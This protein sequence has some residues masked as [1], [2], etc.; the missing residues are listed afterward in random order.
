MFI[1]PRR[2]TS[3]HPQGLSLIF[4]LILVSIIM[5]IAATMTASFLRASQLN[6]DLFR[7]T[8]AYYVARA[9]M[10][11]ALEDASNNGIGYENTATAAASWDTTGNGTD[12]VTGD[13]AIYA[14]GKTL[15]WIDAPTTDSCNGVDF[16]YIPIPG[17]GNAGDSCDFED[18]SQTWY[19][20]SDEACN[21]NKIVY[22]QTVTIPL[23]YTDSTGTQMN[24][25]TSGDLF[26]LKIR[27]PESSS[28]TR[29]SLNSTLDDEVIVNWEIVA[30]CDDG[31]SVDSC[32]ITGYETLG[33]GSGP[34][35]SSG[36]DSR[37]L[38]SVINGASS[39]AVLEEDTEGIDNLQITG[40][41]ITEFLTN[42]DPGHSYSAIENHYLKISVI[43]P[44]IDSSGTSI[45][46]L[47][48]QL[49]T[50]VPFSTTQIIYTADGHADGQLGTYNRHLQAIQSIE[51]N[52][53]INFVIQN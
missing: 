48:W 47:E 25:F 4:A 43:T 52:A 14:Q 38:G 15:T 16:C 1:T 8:Q 34:G 36:S 33:S 37:I 30:E 11:K 44:L 51:N 31:S 18:D 22:G 41:Q 24:D 42:S 12:D 50:S 40:V 20:D 39:Y 27:T 49:E 26:T 45:P 10:E 19:N 6:Q 32:F 13:Y 46:H 9:A 5:V 35:S 21:W 3:Q 7:S 17:T 28:G 53:I 29:P 2:Q 23:F